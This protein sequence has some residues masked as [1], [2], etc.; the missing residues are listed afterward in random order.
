VFYLGDALARMRLGWS[1]DYLME[2]LEGVI[3]SRP[4]GGAYLRLSM[5]PG[6]RVAAKTGALIGLP[7]GLAAAASASRAASAAQAGRSGSERPWV[8]QLVPLQRDIAADD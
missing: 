8:L 1:A 2:T 3:D 5:G 7:A 6:Q 4:A